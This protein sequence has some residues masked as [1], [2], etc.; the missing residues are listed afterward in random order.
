M[1]PELWIEVKRIFQEAIEL[2]VS[3]R[4]AFL[5]KACGDDAAL[6]AEVESLLA[7]HEL[8]HEFIDEPVAVG[9]LNDNIT[10]IKPGERI[11]SYRIVEKIGRGGMGVVF[12]AEREGVGGEV[13]IKVLENVFASPAKQERF[14]SEEKML[15]GLKHQFI[16]QLYDAGVLNDKT[17]WFAMEYVDGIEITKHCRDKS[18]E[19]CLKL[20]RLVCEAVQYAH[21]RMV[22]HRDLKPSNILVRTTEQ[23]CTPKLLD[24]GIAKQLDAVSSPSNSGLTVQMMT[25]GYA[26]P[27]QF[28]GSAT[29]AT[30][31]YSLGVIL[32]ELIAARKPYD[33]DKKSPFEIHQIISENTPE[34]PSSVAPRTDVTGKQSRQPRAGSWADLDVLCLTAMHRDPARR[35]QSVEALIRDIDHY[36]AGEPLEVRGDDVTYKLSKF[37]RRHRSSLTAA[38]G[39]IILGIVLGTF[40]TLRLTRARNEANLAAARTQRIEQFMSKLLTGGNQ[41]S[42][43]SADLKVVTLIDDGARDAQTLSND[44]EVQAELYKTLGNSYRNLGLF[45]KADSLLSLALNQRRTIFGP[46]HPQVAESLV[47]LGLLRMD[48]LKFD[49]AEKLVRDGLEITKRANPVNKTALA[50]ATTALGNVLTTRGDYNAAI[51][52]IEEAVRVLDD[53]RPTLELVEA[54]SQLSDANFYAAHYETCDTLTRRT[55]LVAQELYGQRHFLVAKSLMNLGAIR[56][57]WG[58]YKEAEEFY[59]QALDITQAWY[60]RDHFQTASVMVQLAQPLLYQERYDEVET[61]L[62][63]AL[64]INEKAFSKDHPRLTFVLNELGSLN[65]RRSRWDDAEHYFGRAADLNRKAYG[66][67]NFRTLVAM[68]NLAG[69]YYTKKDF[70]RAESTLREVVDGYAQDSSDHLNMAIARIKLGRVLAKEKKYR[71]AESQTL[72]GYEVATKQKSKPWIKDARGVLVIIYEGLGE[73]DKAKSYREPAAQP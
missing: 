12:L 40:F 28:L 44:P 10:K 21:G 50:S 60:G 8:A 35:Y 2:P 39:V 1:T 42:G 31:V 7:C 27:E 56:V 41:P 33:L 73:P 48:E 37:V 24:F 72:A 19:E 36:L 69:V 61:L 13:A 11:G 29:V 54:L 66:A 51:P 58:N 71:E 46:E 64:E 23:S 70:A 9:L 4:E 32:Y 43:P 5:T 34:K 30:D 20:F 26:A 17:P 67:K 49:E 47:A 65:Y 52:V 53:G 16:A 63:Q 22:I 62:T 57:Q 68:A 18:I 3:D 55:M 25:F 38:A 59:R 15:A 6:R 45:D 14:T